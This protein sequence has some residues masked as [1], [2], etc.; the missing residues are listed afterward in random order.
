MESIQTVRSYL[1]NILSWQEAHLNFE[2]AIHD[3]PKDYRG[4]KPE[5][6]PYSIWQLVE[7]IRIA[8]W[9]ILDFSRNPDY[10]EHTW[11]DDY[12]LENNAPANEAEWEG[13]LESI[14]NDR[15]EFIK[16]LDDPALD[17]LKP[18]PHGSGQT[19]FRQALLIADHT[20]YHVGQIVVLRKLLQKT[21]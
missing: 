14:R 5:G 7:H 10:E 13:S 9:D 17:L 18:F 11:P 12:W 6:F 21:I 15:E 19:L 20:A 1:K 3:L 16:L 8:Q 4:M 2:A